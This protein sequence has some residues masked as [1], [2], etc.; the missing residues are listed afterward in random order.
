MLHRLLPYN[1]PVFWT[2]LSK[3]RA[4]NRASLLVSCRVDASITQQAD[5]E[6]CCPEKV[7]HF[8][9]GAY[10]RRHALAKFSNRQRTSISSCALLRPARRLLAALALLLPDILA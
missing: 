2:S 8:I 9:A 10:L 7:M 4:A 6:F 1:V 3:A 5:M